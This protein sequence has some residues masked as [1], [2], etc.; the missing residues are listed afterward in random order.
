MAASASSSTN[1]SSWEWVKFGFVG[2]L[3]LGT[4]LVVSHV[5]IAEAADSS[6]LMAGGA[7]GMYNGSYLGCGCFWHVQHEVVSRVEE[8]VLGRGKYELTAFTGYAGSRTVGN[9]GRVCYHNFA[10]AADYGSLGHGEVVSVN[11]PDSHA[12]KVAK[13]FFDSVCV[14]GIRRDL[15]DWGAEYRSI[16]GFPGGLDS[17]KGQAFQRAAHERGIYLKAGTGA[18][19]PDDTSGRVYIMDTSM[20]PFHQ[21]E[22]YHQFHDDMTEKYG[23][24]YNAIGAELLR[25]GRIHHTGCP[26]DST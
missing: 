23:A 11:F 18:G 15:Q 19:D 16:V 6:R 1:R 21:A 24:A 25:A 22:V 8:Q 17:A 13:I 5:S 12:D 26:H 20:F 4:V 2:V 10:G 9:D 7:A 3:L 14:R